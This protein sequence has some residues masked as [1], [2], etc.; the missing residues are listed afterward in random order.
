VWTPV[1][2]QRTSPSSFGL[3]ARGW[4]SKRVNGTLPSKEYELALDDGDALQKTIR[5][6]EA[7]AAV[8]WAAELD[9]RGFGPQC[10]KRLRVIVS[11]DVGSRGLRAPR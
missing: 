2:H 3:S 8:Y 1:R 9:R 4:A 11:E 6:G 10:W 7:E 5:R